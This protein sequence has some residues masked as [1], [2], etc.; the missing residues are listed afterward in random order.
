[1]LFS[2]ITRGVIVCIIS[3]MQ[4]D[5]VRLCCHT[6]TAVCA[7]TYQPS[8]MA[9]KLPTWLARQQRLLEKNKPC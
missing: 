5:C 8:Y 1:M 3:V 4:D 7:Y 6:K 2:C 9:A